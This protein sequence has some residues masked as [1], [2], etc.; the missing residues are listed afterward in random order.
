MV[1]Y[2]C[3][4]WH[5]YWLYC[6]VIVWRKLTEWRIYSQCGV[7]D[8]VLLVLWWYCD[9]II[10]DIVVTVLT[11]CIR[12]CYCW[13]SD[14]Y[15]YWWP[16]MIWCCVSSD[17]GMYCYYC[18]WWQVLLWWR[19]CNLLY[20][21]GITDY[22]CY[23]EVT[24]TVTSI[25]LWQ[26]WPVYCPSLT[27]PAWLT[28]II[29]II[30]WPVCGC[31]WLQWLLCDSYNDKAASGSVCVAYWCVVAMCVVASVC[32]TICVAGCVSHL[33]NPS[34][35]NNELKPTVWQWHVLMW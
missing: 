29:I 6:I 32:V 27:D 5:Y 3:I 4:Y 10:I 18:Q 16:V 1:F 17:D 9:I 8:I 13:P 30:S 31:V 23:C 14:C 25:V 12:Y 26:Y 2:Y 24:V 21:S 33:T 7:V 34:G 20:W 35:I 28:P 11:D 15:C 19:H 22:Y